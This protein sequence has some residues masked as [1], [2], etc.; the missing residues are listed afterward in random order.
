MFGNTLAVLRNRRQIGSQARSD[1]LENKTIEWFW[2]E[3]SNWSLVWWRR[4][5]PL[6]SKCLLSVRLSIV[7]TSSQDTIDYIR[8]LAICDGSVSVCSRRR[9]F[10]LRCAYQILSG[11]KW[12]WRF[13][14]DAFKVTQSAKRTSRLALHPK[15]LFA[16]L[17]TRHLLHAE[18]FSMV[19]K[20]T[21]VSMPLPEGQRINL[22]S[23]RHSNMFWWHRDKTTPRFPP[24]WM[25]SIAAVRKWNYEDG[26]VKICCCSRLVD[27][28]ARGCSCK[29]SGREMGMLPESGRVELKSIVRRLFFCLSFFFSFWVFL[30]NWSQASNSAS[31]TFKFM[32]FHFHLKLRMMNNFR[33]GPTTD[34]QCTC[35]MSLSLLILSTSEDRSRHYHW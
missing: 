26:S 23:M 10:H 8:G 19:M 35:Q 7:R 12:L 16:N 34:E 27:M 6:R 24:N 4:L 3:V 21:A 31:Q 25:I 2:L 20:L 14:V 30:M 18:C 28:T 33:L 32:L 1:C 22:V 9:C 29:S 11:V 5:S 15:L 13:N 17:W